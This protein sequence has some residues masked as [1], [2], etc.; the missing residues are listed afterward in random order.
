LPTILSTAQIFN[1]SSG[2][3]LSNASNSCLLAG[4]SPSH[5]D[6][7]ISTRITG[8]RSC[9]SPI[10]W[11]GPHVKI[12]QLKTSSPLAGDFCPQLGHHDLRVV[13][14]GD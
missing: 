4:S 9:D 6:Q 10:A 7:S 14:H 11:F 5:F 2:H 12:A 8:I 13:G 1:A 3:G